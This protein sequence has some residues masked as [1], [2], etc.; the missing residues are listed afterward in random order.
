LG[1]DERFSVAFETMIDC[2]GIY[3][4]VRDASGQIVDFRIEYVNAAACRSNQLSREEQVG[5]GLCEILPGHRES[6]LFADYCQVVETR[7]PL[8]KEMLLYTD[9]YG[10]Q[11]LQRAFDIRVTPLDDGFVAAW[12]DVTGRKQAEERLRFLAEIG[13]VLGASLDHAET[14][15]TAARLAIPTIADACAIYSFEPD[16]LLHLCAAAAT[17]PG[18]EAAIHRDFAVLEPDRQSMEPL[19]ELIETHRPVLLYVPPADVADGAT[20]SVMRQFGLHSGLNLPL[21]A[22]E[23]LLGVLSLGWI[24][25]GR[26]YDERDMPFAEEVARRIALALENARLYTELQAAKGQAD[27]SAALLNTLVMHAPVGFAVHDAELRHLLINERLAGVNGLPVADHLGRTLTEVLPPLA[28]T[29]EPL[30]RQVLQTG[31]PVL[32]HEFPLAPAF[33]PRD[34]HHWLVNYYPV[35]RED[36]NVFGVGSVVVDITERRRVEVRTRFL[37]TASRALAAS[38]DYTTTLASVADLAVPAFADL[39]LVHLVDAQGKLHDVGVACADPERAALVRTM[40]DRYPPDPQHSS[41]LAEVLHSRTIRFEP[42]LPP[43]FPERAGRDQ[44]HRALIRQ[45]GPRAFLTAPLCVDDTIL[46]VLQLALTEPGRTWDTAD[47]QLVE[48]LASR[49]ARAIER[50]QLYQA[51]QAAHALAE[52]AAARTARLLSVAEALARSLTVEQ[53]ARLVL[54]TSVGA[55]G[56]FAGGLFLLCADER[57]FERAASVGYP[58]EIAAQWQRFPVDA[59]L[60][61]AD[62]L[63]IRAPVWIEDIDAAAER[64]PGFVAA[65][66][67]FTGA[68]AVIPLIANDQVVGGLG[69]SFAQPRPFAPDDQAFAVALAQQCAQVLMRVQLDTALRRSEARYRSLVRHFPNGTVYLFD[70]DLRYQIAGG[71]ALA[72]FG[73]TPEH[74][75]GRTIWEVLPPELLDVA[76]PLYRATLAG[77]APTELEQDYHDHHFRR[78]PVALHDDT[79]AIVA[80]MVISYEITQIKRAEVVLRELNATLEQ[81]VAERTAALTVEVNERQRAL[82]AL[83][84]SEATLR[85][86]LDQAPALL[87]TT[88]GDLRITSLRGAERVLFPGGLQ[89]L[90]GQTIPEALSSLP[91]PQV[92]A[93]L[94]AHR[95]ALQG[96]PARYQLAV[97]GRHLDVQVEP[98]RTTDGAIVGCIALATDSTQRQHDAEALRAANAQLSAL[99]AQVARSRDLLQTLFDGLADGLLLL[100][101]TGRVLAANQTLALLLGCQVADVLQRPWAEICAAR[102]P[103]CPAAWVLDSLGHG[104]SEQRQVRYAPADGHPRVLD[105]TTLPLP[106]SAQLPAQLIVRLVDSTERLQLETIAMRS[107]RYIASGTLAAMV[108]HEVNT[109]LQAVK[110]FLFLLADAAPDERPHFLA[111]AREELQ[112]IGTIVSQLLD[113]YRPM[114]GDPAPV[115]LNALIARVLLLTRASCE[116]QNV[117][118]VVQPAP[119][120]PAIWGRA[121]QLIQLLLNLVVNALEAMPDGGTL[122]VG[123][124]LEPLAIGLG[125]PA[126]DL[127][128]GPVITLTVRD[129]GDGIPPSVADTLFEPFVTSKPQGT[130]LGLAICRTIVARH[131][132]TIVAHSRPGAGAVFTV[133]LPAGA[134]ER[135]APP[136]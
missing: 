18:V 81:Q 22:G 96:K 84:Q 37:D 26:S 21:L 40:L 67:L 100:D 65:V 112:R 11:L 49:C 130:G 1:H 39:C 83:Y 135:Q 17:D 9:A 47:V 90:A 94:A 91:S 131:G 2:L 97:A 133:Q 12:R 27:E 13:A 132:G 69:L 16:G 10:G 126:P 61:I 44:V 5:R 78:I 119:D 98:L 68:V 45:I 120:V 123:S 108:A 128:P 76:E 29:V 79:G 113:L 23:R 58:P 107:E 4:A 20:Q 3:R 92:A 115:D 75:E 31:E 109:P 104:R 85:L 124:S 56:A 54:D 74:L 99:A 25:L 95:Q 70:Q 60:P 48:E 114:T 93:P 136:R 87:W 51:E 38:L 63:R 86:I 64:Y 117:R 35:K 36:G 110:N 6:S 73:L 82:A 55:L 122:T 30:L 53:A 28:P 102:T 116:R 111:L 118:L 33:A 129:T 103:P 89:H 66:R 19:R 72:T 88:D 59:P 127:D 134:V 62:A 14:L 34:P 105:I 121:D 52:Q 77:T 8:E 106:A 57:S 24:T 125:R 46:G 15:Q 41:G 101:H 50:A 42:D 80:G 43:D 71:D 7:I 32:A